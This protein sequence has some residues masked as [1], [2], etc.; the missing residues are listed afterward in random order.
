MR[1]PQCGQWNRAHF[2][3][4][5]KCGASLRADASNPMPSS[6]PVSSVPVSVQEH[7]PAPLAAQDTARFVPSA[8]A[9]PAKAAEPTTQS[10]TGYDPSSILA[11]LM[12]LRK[13]TEE[14]VKAVPVAPPE[15]VREDPA[16]SFTPEPAPAVI[17]QHVAPAPQATPV[18]SPAPVYEAIAEPEPEPATHIAASEP[19]TKPRGRLSRMQ[20]TAQLTTELHAD[21]PPPEDEPAPPPPVVNIDD[22]VLPDAQNLVKNVRPFGWNRDDGQPVLQAPPTPV[23]TDDGRSRRDQLPK[24]HASA[25]TARRTSRHA[26]PEAQPAEP[27]AEPAPSK[28]AAK[29][30]AEAEATRHHVDPSKLAPV[31]TIQSKR[32]PSF[33]RSLLPIAYLLLMVAIGYGGYRGYLWV[34][35]ILPE[36]SQ[37]IR[38]TAAIDTGLPRPM[39][40]TGEMEGEPV[41]ILTFSGNDGDFISLPEYN[42]KNLQIVAGTLR[43]MIPDKFWIGDNPDDDQERFHV[44]INPKLISV[45]GIEKRMAPVEYYVE[46]P[47]SPIDLVEPAER[48]IDTYAAIQRIQFKVTPGSSVYLDNNDIRDLVDKNGVVTQNYRVKPEGE[49]IV[50]ISVKTPGFR[51]NIMTLSITRPY[52]DIPIDLSSPPESTSTANVS[53]RGTT[54]AGTSI[55]IETPHSDLVLDSTIGTFSFIAKLDK[56]GSNAVII[57]AKKEG[58]Q[59]SRLPLTILYEPEFGEYSNRA[60]KFADEYD[61]LLTNSAQR[62]GQ[63]YRVD[64]TIISMEAATSTTPMM[65]YFDGGGST[66][67]QMPVYME[68]H[69]NKTWETGRKM[70]VYAH[71]IGTKDGLPLLE[72]MYIKY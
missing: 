14:A 24:L 17:S 58:R 56:I 43:V 9:T 26:E 32:R 62:M 13:P 45:A 68:Y 29:K 6:G 4:C 18:A 57:T 67:K 65:V 55:I 70:S 22:A 50:E 21:A 54:D 52:M 59:D 36:P 30:A 28:R 41:H 51:K 25:R 20:L 15:P 53:I 72:A 1:C 66:G 33:L 27:P 35:D 63:I 3:A 31:S 23:L 8:S 60:W 48:E 11:Q 10:K 61:F 2:A 47:L 37:D 12:H 49:N 44:E 40:E 42:N 7:T 19:N 46:V 64:G 69:G 5:L 71:V 16:A 34:R 38:A 39:I